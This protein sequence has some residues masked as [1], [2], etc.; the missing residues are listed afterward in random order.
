MMPALPHSLSAARLFT[1]SR[2]SP[3]W[4][5]HALQIR[6]W[7]CVHHFPSIHITSLICVQIVFIITISVG[8]VWLPLAFSSR[9]FC[10]LIHPRMEIPKLIH[11]TYH[12]NMLTVI[13]K[14]ANQNF[15]VQHIVSTKHSL[16][17]T[18]WVWACL[19]MWMCVFCVHW[20][21]L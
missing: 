20:L 17:H 5:I 11:F 13:W 9:S 19:R 15:G 10:S 14:I 1:D 18:H 4:K 7:W 3:C 12:W 2:I 21:L 16:S 6:F 8:F